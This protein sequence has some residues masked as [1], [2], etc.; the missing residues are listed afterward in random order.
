MVLYGHDTNAIIPEPI[1]PQSE[2]ELIQAYAVLQ[3][4]L[5]NCGLCPNFQMLDN[6]CPAVLNNYMRREG[7][8][9]QHVPPH[10]H[11]TNSAKRAIK[12]F[13]DHLIAGISTCYPGFLMQL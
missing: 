6:E 13:K 8:M 4:K 9:F 11:R 3:Y 10:L 2:S 5:T 7:F 1:K 12:A